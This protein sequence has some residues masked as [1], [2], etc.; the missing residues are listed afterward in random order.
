MRGGRG[1]RAASHLASLL[2]RPPEFDL[3]LAQARPLLVAST[4][5]AA[6]T[7]APG[8]LHGPCLQGQSPLLRAQEANAAP[9]PAR[10]R[11][12]LRQGSPSPQT[13]LWRKWGATKRVSA[14]VPFP[15]AGPPEAPPCGCISPPQPR[16]LA[17][18]PPPVRS[19]VPLPGSSRPRPSPLLQRLWQGGSWKPRK[20][21]WKSRS[22]PAP[23]PCQPRTRLG[24]PGAQAE[25]RWK[26]SRRG[27]CINSASRA[28]PQIL[29]FL[30]LPSLSHSL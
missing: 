22:P 23:H 12:R 10:G 9:L 3:T 21:Q 15:P 20:A 29:L 28:Q 13:P 4:P 24:V 17:Q 1:V 19:H 6:R 30:P 27:L 26:A 11:G 7:G 18:R 25:S 16:L 8:T 2:P 5:V 14:P